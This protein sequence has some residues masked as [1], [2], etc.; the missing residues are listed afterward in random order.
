M[1]RKVERKTIGTFYGPAR[2]DHATMVAPA[3]RS[4]GLRQRKNPP[5]RPSGHAAQGIEDEARPEAGAQHPPV[6]DEARHGKAEEEGG[7]WCVGQARATRH[8]IDH[9][10]DRR[11]FHHREGATEAEAAHFQG[12]AEG[13]M[14]PGNEVRAL[15]RE[16]DAV[17]AHQGRRQGEGVRPVEEQEGEGR[18][19][20][21]GI[22]PEEDARSHE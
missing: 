4:L 12:A 21:P 5:A 18:F 10:A 1:H 7:V 15:P 6:E 9:E 8:E 11:R 22:P 17:V 3:L 2:L 14:R 16:A 19:A 20:G 13:R